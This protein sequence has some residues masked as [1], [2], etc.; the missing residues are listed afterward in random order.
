M[1]PRRLRPG[2]AAARREHR[3][4][5][6]ARLALRHRPAHRGSWAGW[7]RRRGDLDEAAARFEEALEISRQAG[8]HMFVPW[9]LWG[10]ADVYRLAGDTESA[11]AWM[12]EA[13]AAAEAVGNEHVVAFTI[14]AR[15]RIA[16]AAGRYDEAE[17]LDLEALR[18]RQAV[19]D[20]AGILD[21]LES[22]AGLAAVRGDAAKAARLLA[23][24]DA[25]RILQPLRPARPPAGRAR[26]RP[27][28]GLVRPA[29]GRV[30]PGLGRGPR[31]V[32]GR[33]RRPRPAARTTSPPDR[34]PPAG[35][36]PVD[37]PRP[38]ARLP[39]RHAVRRGRE[40]AYAVHGPHRRRAGDRPRRRRP[41]PGCTTSTSV[42]ATPPSCSCTPTRC[43]RRCGPP[44]FPASPPTTG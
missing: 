22:L 38:P 26:R 21:S 27:G 19:G 14:W 8:M 37:R 20:G 13:R 17:A 10:R 34:R 16:R 41:H 30:R 9:W 24:A 6:P 43:H 39:S 36:R 11:L 23:A 1:A 42:P 31:P 15:A 29:G 28:A 35:C 25:H 5:P 4:R 18:R 2:P 40:H 3:D 44:S 32:P 12:V 7:P 33:G